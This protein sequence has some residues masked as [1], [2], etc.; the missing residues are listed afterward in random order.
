MYVEKALNFCIYFNEIEK[1]SHI[2][3]N[4]EQKQGRT[5][6]STKYRGIILANFAIKNLSL[7]AASTALE[8]FVEVYE[9]EPNE[10]N[11]RNY[12]LAKKIMTQLTRQSNQAKKARILSILGDQAESIKPFMKD[13]E[14]QNQDKIPKDF[15]CPLS[16][17]S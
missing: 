7:E 14:S 1:A 8:M 15:F 4:F 12:L 11:Q 17:V 9:E 5:K 16:L 3:N 2:L 13:F 10:K 6:M